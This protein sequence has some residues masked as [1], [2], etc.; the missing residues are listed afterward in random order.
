MKRG[1]FDSDVYPSNQFFSVALVK[2]RFHIADYSQKKCP[3]NET[4]GLSGIFLSK[5]SHY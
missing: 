1:R 2:K 3:L 5:R 4:L